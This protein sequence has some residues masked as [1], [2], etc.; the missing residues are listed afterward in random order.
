M[1]NE[2]LNALRNY[3]DNI[4]EL[5]DL[6]QK[7]H[8]STVHDA[9]QSAAKF[10]YSKHSVPV[11]GVPPDS[12]LYK[13]QIRAQELRQEIRRAEQFVRTLPQHRLRKAVRMYYMD[14]NGSRITWEDV[15]YSV[16]F[17]SGGEALRMA[18]RRAIKTCS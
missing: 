13:L 12:D 11:D 5:S 15:A 17:S 3:R 14:D 6:E 18:I 7:L 9:V 16:G 2:F 4:S 1:A 10:P 8:D